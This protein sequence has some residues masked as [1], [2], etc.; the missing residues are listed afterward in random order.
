MAYRYILGDT[1]KKVF[2]SFNVDEKTREYILR[3]LFSEGYTAKGICYAAAMSEEKLYRFIGDS[4]F[5]SVFINEV[6]KN[7]LKPGDP[8]WENRKKK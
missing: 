6:R 4:R 3:T 5:E 1:P 8:R 2:D 7:A